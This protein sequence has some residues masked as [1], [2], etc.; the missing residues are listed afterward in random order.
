MSDLTRLE[1][2]LLAAEKDNAALRARIGELEWLLIAFSRSEDKSGR[3]RCDSCSTL[4]PAHTDGCRI[5]KALA[6][7]ETTDG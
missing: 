5:G 1:R 6:G 3:M 4:V 2:E 7:K